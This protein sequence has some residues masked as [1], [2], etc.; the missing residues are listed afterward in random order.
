MPLHSIDAEQSVM[1]SVGHI[2][3]ICSLLL[4]YPAPTH[5][6]DSQYYYPL[7]YYVILTD[8][9]VNS[10]AFSQLEPANNF[11]GRFKI[12]YF[13]RDADDPSV[14]ITVPFES[15]K[16]SHINYSIQ[17]DTMTSVYAHSAKPIFEW[18]AQEFPPI[19]WTIELQKLES[20]EV[21]LLWN[22]T[23]E[24]PMHTWLNECSSENYNPAIIY[25]GH[26]CPYL[27]ESPAID[28]N[29]TFYE[30][31]DLDYHT[32]PPSPTYDRLNFRGL[33]IAIIVMCI[34]VLRL[35]GRIRIS[36]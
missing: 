24:G 36:L 22:R 26:T 15:W 5:S 7:H 18:H 6:L 23:I 3:L 33:A 11:T 1:K 16:Y 19:T 8:V 35:R 12:D 29:M 17:P 25:E 4:S 21:Q 9:W 14:N 30:S 10:S 13:I 32:Y 28:L 20:N 31:I 2:V 34:S 27:V